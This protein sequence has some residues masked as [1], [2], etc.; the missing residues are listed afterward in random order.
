ML[1]IEST[2]RGNLQLVE[3]L[4]ITI[5]DVAMATNETNSILMYKEGVSREDFS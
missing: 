5:D 4:M 2:Y 3:I 1:Q